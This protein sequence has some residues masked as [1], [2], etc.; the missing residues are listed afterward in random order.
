MS[1]W[2]AAI[3]PQAI[4][5]SGAIGGAPRPGAW[6]D[7]LAQKFNFLNRPRRILLAL[8]ATWVVHTFD[9]G[10]TLLEANSEHFR[11]LNPVAATL[12]QDD[13][14]V[15]VYKIALL[16]LASVIILP[17]RRRHLAELA[18]WL[19]LATSIYVAVRWHCYY[20]SL[21]TGHINPFIAVD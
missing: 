2:P 16:L 18:T 7:R 9:L 19:M 20:L 17:L 11:E 6:L 13:Q 21:A 3:W 15:I 12:L 4:P 1:V 5:R 10:F 14:A 8:A